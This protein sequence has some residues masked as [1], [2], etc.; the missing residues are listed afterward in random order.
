MSYT[1]EYPR[2]AVTAD[3]ILFH[4]AGDVVSILLIRRKHPPFEGQWALPG[5]FMNMEE[6]LEQAARRELEEETNI[7]VHEL[8]PFGVFDKPDRDPRGRTITRVFYGF[9]E[10]KPENAA[11]SDDAGELSWFSIDKLPELAFD[12][13]KIIASAVKEVLGNGE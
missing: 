7:R 2:P 6:T 9:I 3:T 13:A 8:I 10:N 12:H 4:R 1:Y 11:A 5:G